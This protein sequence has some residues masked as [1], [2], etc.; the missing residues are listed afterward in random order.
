MKVS[1]HAVDRYIERWRP[2]LLDRK[3]AEQELQQLIIGAALINQEWQPYGLQFT[4]AAC[5]GNRRVGLVVLT[6]FNQ[7]EPSRG[8]A[9]DPTTHELRTVLP[10]LGAAIACATFT[11]SREAPARHPLHQ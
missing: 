11:D 5:L 2:T 10:D 9:H 8:D 7:Y 4:F 6:T 3:R 1:E